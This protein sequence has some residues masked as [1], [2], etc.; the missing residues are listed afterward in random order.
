MINLTDGSF[1]FT[2]YNKY[3]T[4]QTTMV[5][6]TRLLD[7]DIGSLATNFSDLIGMITH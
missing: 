1:G 4:R 3:G 5:V 7:I 6:L 2:I